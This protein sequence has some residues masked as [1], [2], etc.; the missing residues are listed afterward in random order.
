MCG[1]FHLTV[2]EPGICPAV[3]NFITTGKKAVA[4]GLSSSYSSHYFA[5]GTIPAGRIVFLFGAMADQKE[6]LLPV[7]RL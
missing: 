7:E 3:S 5:T 4:P 1:R 6:I 2:F